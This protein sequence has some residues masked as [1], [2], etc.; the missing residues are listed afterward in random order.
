MSFKDLQDFGRGGLELSIN[1]K[2]YVIPEA[3]GETGLLVE[4]TLALGA[5]Q[6][7][8]QAKLRGLTEK[9]KA[10]EKPTPDEQITAADRLT[11][12]ELSSLQEDVEAGNGLTRRLLGDAMDEMLAD[13]VSWA[14]LKHVGATA[15]VLVNADEEAARTFWEGGPRQGEVQTPAPNRASK[16]AASRAAGSTTRRPASTSGT[17]TRKT[18]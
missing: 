8:L 7:R 16:R 3:S 9:E 2:V 5:K 12:S 13:G 11:D 14:M 4:R 10:G 15:M 18:P 6:S 1:G 17:R